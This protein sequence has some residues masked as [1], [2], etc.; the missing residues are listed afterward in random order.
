MMLG[1]LPLLAVSVAC[2]G[3]DFT[4]FGNV[5]Q[6]LVD[7]ALFGNVGLAGLI[8]LVMFT[9]MII[10]Y[11]FPVTTII[12]VGIALSYVLFLMTGADLFMGL[13]IFG[14]VIGGSI[15]IIAILNHLNR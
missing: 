1:E 15:V 12:P 13:L 8:I 7:G 14:G 3:L 10:R 5:G 9:A 4:N 6:C 11:N 2:Q